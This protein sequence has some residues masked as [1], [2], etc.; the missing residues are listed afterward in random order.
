VTKT[1]KK[2][3]L[4]TRSCRSSPTAP[5]RYA[6]TYIDTI[7]LA[8]N[9]LPFSDTDT[10][11]EMAGKKCSNKGSPMSDDISDD[12][13]RKGLRQGTLTKTKTSTLSLLVG[14]MPV[15]IGGTD[16]I[17]KPHWR[18]PP[19]SQL[20]MAPSPARCS[21]SYKMPDALLSN[22]TLKISDP[23]N[24][25]GQRLKSKIGTY[26]SHKPFKPWQKF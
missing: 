9:P 13:R 15:P 18:R 21:K 19:T 10:D 14:A 22:T 7:T 17:K 3:P 5:H 8:I 25:N 23:T 26:C 2:I 4:A 6:N 24:G 11:S 16:A 1:I 12:D 20:E